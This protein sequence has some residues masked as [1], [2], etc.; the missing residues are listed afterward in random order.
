[1][2]F[3][4]TLIVILVAIAFLRNNMAKIKESAKY[5]ALHLW[6]RSHKIKPT[7][8][9]ICNEN[10]PS[11]IAKISKK[12]TRN[13]N[14]YIW[15]CKKCH[16]YLDKTNENLGDYLKGKIGKENPHWKGG[17]KF[18]TCLFCGKKFI[19]WPCKIRNEKKVKCSR[20]C[21]NR[22]NMKHRNQTGEKNGNWKGGPSQYKRNLERK[23]IKK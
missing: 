14:D 16:T 2:V 6:V 5:A 7:K 11:E 23:N 13:I 8:C 4:S 20:L 3:V 22:W 21:A 17:K 18:Y 9:E 12:Y 15:V 19:R 1:M 10:P